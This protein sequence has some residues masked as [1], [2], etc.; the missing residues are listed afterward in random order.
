M[1]AWFATL[2]VRV[3]IV[4][5]AARGL[6]EFAERGKWWRRLSYH[7]RDQRATLRMTEREV[8]S[9]EELPGW[10]SGAANLVEQ[11]KRINWRRAAVRRSGGRG[12]VAAFES[13]RRRGLKADDRGPA[14]RFDADYRTHSRTSFAVGD[15]IGFPSLG[16]GF[17]GAGPP[18]RRAAGVQAGCADGPAG[19]SLRD[20]TRFPR[21]FLYR[22]DRKSN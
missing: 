16:V 8:E 15:V 18:S 11:E 19:V 9:V 10:K 2:G 20:F 6:L 12:N 7:M 5:K 4:E 13:C 1:R 21:F 22:Q 3:I 14:S 17:H